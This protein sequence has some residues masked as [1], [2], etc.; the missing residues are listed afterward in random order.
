MPA[1]KVLET[2]L[3]CTCSAQSALS[4]DVND[5]FDCVKVEK[6]FGE[7]FLR[8]SAVLPVER[9]LKRLAISSRN[10]DR[11]RVEGCRPGFQH[12]HVDGW[13]LAQSCCDD[14]ACGAAADD[15][16]V[17]AAF[18]KLTGGRYCGQHASY[19]GIWRSDTYM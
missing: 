4:D 14:E 10:V 2:L 17:E 18:R 11:R 7:I 8:R 15:Q 13:I 19:S 12:A 3:I 1:S 16:V 5:D 6:K 9:R